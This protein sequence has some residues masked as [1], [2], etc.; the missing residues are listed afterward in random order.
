MSHCTHFFAV[1]IE[2]PQK[3]E[4]SIPFGWGRRK[5]LVPS[6]CIL[7]ILC[8]HLE[9]RFHHALQPLRGA[10]N[11]KASPLPPAPHLLM[12]D[13]LLIDCLID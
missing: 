10:A 4:R 9:V 13:R 11:L 5:G 12:T 2:D 6:V 3:G 7:C 1:E 8:R